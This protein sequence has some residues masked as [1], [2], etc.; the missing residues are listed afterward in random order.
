MK[1]KNNPN[2]LLTLLDGCR[3][4]ERSSR[5]LLYQQYYSYGLTVC[6]HYSNNREEAEEIL[7]DGF[8]KVFSK[9]KQYKRKAAFKSW[10]RQILVHAAIDYYRKF[11]QKVNLEYMNFLSKVETVEN[12]ALY[13]LSM[14]DALKLLQQLSPSY[15]MVFNLFVLEG[16][17]HSEIAKLLN[18]STGTSKS[19]LAK[20]RKKLKKLAT[21]YYQINPKVSNI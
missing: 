4:G 16:Y 21:N 9:I 5:K 2:F 3:K 13:N 17:S 1:N 20:A 12:D 14:D 11:H 18:I 19:N 8:V 7:N 6:L 15:R 10:L